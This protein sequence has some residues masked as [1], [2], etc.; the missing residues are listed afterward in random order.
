M[1]E[2]MAC[3][4]NVSNDMLSSQ[5]HIPLVQWDKVPN[6]SNIACRFVQKKLKHHSRRDLSYNDQY[7]YLWVGI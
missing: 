7:Q 5:T 2:I 1:I 3:K 4:I 6:L